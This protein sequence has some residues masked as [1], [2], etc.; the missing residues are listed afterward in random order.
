MD[1]S[2]SYQIALTLIP[3]LGPVK[4]KKLLEQ[5]EPHEIF[6]CPAKDLEKIEGIGP[7]LASH[8]VQFNQWKRVEEEL[9][10]IERNQIKTLFIGQEGY[11]NRLLHC[12]DSPLLLFVKGNAHLN[13][14]RMIAVVG[15]R[16]NTLAGKLA[17]EKLIEALCP[18]NISIVSGLA[19]GI[20]TIAHQAALRKNLPTIGVLAHGLDRI[21]P[22]ANRSL[23][24]Q[25]IEQ[26]GSLLTENRKGVQA[27]E[28]LFPKR[29]RIVAGMTDATIVIES[30]HKG[31]SL[32]TAQLAADY[33]REV[34]ALPGRVTDK[35]SSGCLAL[36]KKQRALLFTCAEDITAW[37]GWTIEPHLTP[38]RKK[39]SKEIVENL[40][41]EEKILH[42]IIQKNESVNFELL[43][44]ET[45]W[46]LTK[47]SEVLLNMELA[48]LI[49]SLPGNCY[50]VI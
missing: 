2:L 27:E 35:Y 49:V 29:N 25:I 48:G 28:F 36:I 16:R 34:F 20:D 21:Y 24:K 45:S 3:Q 40:S 26:E 17:T 10:F 41:A 1:T 7:L 33:G 50:S 19:Y 23:A 42:R 37:L 11:P 9:R 22:P 18:Y 14:K 6:N 44:Q 8:I 12:N 30:D 5:L 31:G 15:T 39:E 32:I 46:P 13:A 43:I 38:T 4:G 47:L